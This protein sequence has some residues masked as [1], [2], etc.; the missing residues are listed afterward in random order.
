MA[1]MK[2]KNTSCIRCYPVIWEVVCDFCAKP[3]HPPLLFPKTA[4][5]RRMCAYCERDHAYERA[6]K[7]SAAARA[8]KAKELEEK[9]KKSSQ[10][11]TEAK[12][13][14]DKIM[15]KFA[16]DKKKKGG[17]EKGTTC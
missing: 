16:A 4:D 11:K 1:S 7:A 3:E 6:K 13:A 5:G 9:V 15:A 8:E 12:V 2:C 17:T 14:L 10:E